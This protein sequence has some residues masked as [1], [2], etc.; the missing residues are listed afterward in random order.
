[1]RS[2]VIFIAL[3]LAGCLGGSGAGTPVKEISIQTISFDALPVLTVGASSV[4]SATSSSNLPVSFEVNTILTCA[5]L[6]CPT[7]PQPACSITANVVTALTS[8][9]CSIIATQA[10]NANYSSV[11]AT[12]EISIPLMVVKLQTSLGTIDIELLDTE[13][14]LTV[15]NFLSYV[16]S[17]AYNNSIIHRSI[18]NFIIQGGGFTNVL[19]AIPANA[20]VVNEFSAT[21]SNLRGTIAMAKVDG[22]PNSATNGWFIN[23]SDNSANLDNQNGGF[24]VFGR[25]V[26]NG[27]QVA[28][29]IAALP[30]GV[31]P[32]FPLLT[33]LVNGQLTQ[34]NLVAVSIS[35]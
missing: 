6:G 26:G 11:Q 2:G 14:P 33:P 30:V 23:L 25:V 27:M 34:A 21:R 8:G 7:P 17:G 18:P 24:T 10:G 1:M 16:N 35:K 4:I 5:A 3:F 12:Q 19:G 31:Y 15:A 9:A 22:N 13:A 32:N 28:D 20:P 29:A